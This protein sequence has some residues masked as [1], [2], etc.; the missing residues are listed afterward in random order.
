MK[1]IRPGIWVYNGLF[2]LVDA[3]QEQSEFRKVFKF[4]LDLIDELIS[5][6]NQGNRHVIEHN[7]LIPTPV[8]LIDFTFS[9]RKA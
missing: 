3:W 8:K 9:F 2:R 7:R 5:G 4:K 1:K 6:A